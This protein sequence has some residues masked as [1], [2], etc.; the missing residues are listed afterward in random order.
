M[1]WTQEFDHDSWREHVGSAAAAKTNA[2]VVERGPGGRAGVL[3][4]SFGQNGSR[5]GIDVRHT[6]AD[7][8]VAPR[9]EVYYSY[10][11]YFPADFEFIGDGKMGGLAGTT[12]DLEPFDA[13][14]GGHYDERSFSVRA[15]WKEDRGVVMYLYARHA[16][17]RD[18]YDPQHYGYGIPKRF[19]KKDGTTAGVF[20]PGRWHRIEHRVRLNTPGRNDGLYELWVDGHKGVSLDDVQYRTAAHAD[21]KINQIFSAWFFGGSPDEYPTRRSEAYSDDWALTSTYRG[22]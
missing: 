11:V 10:D 21:L 7:L 3:R 8:G 2:T 20:T 13:S 18:F 6:F 19:V 16:D 15:M 17:G 4:V 9:E 1:L 5:W 12:D 22:L 14:S